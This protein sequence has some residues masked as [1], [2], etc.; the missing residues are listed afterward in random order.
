MTVIFDVLIVI[1]FV[2][3]SVEERTATVVQ[4]EA[5]LRQRLIVEEEQRTQAEHLQRRLEETE[6]G[7]NNSEQL[8]C[9]ELE[10]RL[11][12]LENDRTHY[13]ELQTRLESISKDTVADLNRALEEQKASLEV[14]VL[15]FPIL[16]F[17]LLEFLS[18]LTHLLHL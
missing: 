7:G 10:R 2:S 3:Q 13:I 4:L 5:S 12:E 18:D 16:Y 9:S 8:R 17:N 6:N 1:F 11:K 14:N 15:I